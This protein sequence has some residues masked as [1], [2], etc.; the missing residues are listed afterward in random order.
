M[1]TLNYFTN[2]QL[3]PRCCNAGL[4]TLSYLNPK[5][6]SFCFIPIFFNWR[7]L[8]LLK[9]RKKENRYSSIN[10]KPQVQLLPGIFPLNL[11]MFFESEYSWRSTIYFETF[12]SYFSADRKKMK[13]DWHM[14]RKKF[15]I[16]ELKH[17]R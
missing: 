17:T 3:S 11:W 9:W 2:I 10:E 16:Y 8:Y 1:I 14:N 7:M 6:N 4:V 13:W 15:Q 5:F 12:E